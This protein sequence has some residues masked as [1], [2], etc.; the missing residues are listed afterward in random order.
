MR[1]RLL[2]AA[3]LA[4][5]GLLSAIVAK[6]DGQGSNAQKLSLDSR[7]KPGAAQCAEKNEADFY[8]STEL[9][10]WRAKGDCASAFKFRF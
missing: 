8:G 3:K 7:G 5:G 6:A 1:G 4:L 2:P 10:Q 9:D